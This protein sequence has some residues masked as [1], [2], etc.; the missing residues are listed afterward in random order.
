[1]LL[2]RRRG[3]I[4]IAGRGSHSH[5]AKAAWWGDDLFCLEVMQ[6]AGGRAVTFSSQVEPHPGRLGGGS[7]R[8]VVEHANRRVLIVTTHTQAHFD[9][10][11]IVA[12]VH[13]LHELR[14]YLDWRA[15]KGAAPAVRIAKDN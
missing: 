8:V 4:S 10:P 11:S 5:A 12:R 13:Q 3:L 6:L 2:F 7:R 9:H 1:M 15:G 14:D